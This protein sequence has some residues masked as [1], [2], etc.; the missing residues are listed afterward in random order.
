M[1]TLNHGHFPF[2]YTHLEGEFF[3][4]T[5]IIMSISI[6]IYWPHVCDP[7]GPYIKLVN[8]FIDPITPYWLNFINYLYQHIN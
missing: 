1:G 3:I 5:L 2:N 7:L 4:K 6:D 8:N